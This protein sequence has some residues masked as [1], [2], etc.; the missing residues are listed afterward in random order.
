MLKKRKKE[1]GN[2]G[3]SQLD[4]LLGLICAIFFLDT[5][6]SV[7]TMGWASITWIV[8]IGIFFFLTGSLACAEL[9]AA[10]P[11]DGGFAGWTAR[12]FGS[13]MGAF[14]GYLYWAC[15]A[16]WLSSN[17][18]LFVNIFQATF[19]LELSKLAAALLNLFV[20][21]AMLAILLLPS[22]N[23]K[24]MYNYGAIVKIGIGIAL[25]AAGV[26]CFAKGGTQANPFQISEFKPLWVRRWFSFRP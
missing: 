20:I 26:V 13:K 4:M 25:I 5:I 6:P 14:V 1:S 22:K 8:I 2:G 10:Y 21:Y 9:G 24:G 23:S 19:G 11:D 17:S 7:A 16:V 15:N 12:A 18:T 3:M